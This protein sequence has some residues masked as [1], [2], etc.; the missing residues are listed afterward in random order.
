METKSPLCQHLL[1]DSR[2]EKEDPRLGYARCKQFPRHH[3]VR[4]AEHQL[5]VVDAVLT[6]LAGCK[7]VW[8][9]IAQHGAASEKR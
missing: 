9:E 4:F 1:Q 6:N 8:E 2:D 5:Q 7:K 3:D